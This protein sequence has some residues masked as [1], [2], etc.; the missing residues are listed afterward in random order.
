MRQRVRD[1]LMV[2]FVAGVATAVAS[3][4]LSQKPAAAPAR[5]TMDAGTASGMAAMAAGGGGAMAMLRGQ[6]N[7]PVRELYLR[8]GS[9]QAP[10]GEAKADHFLPDGTRL[11]AS[12]PLLTPRTAS[13]SR[14][15]YREGNMQ[16]PKGRLLLFWGCGEKAGPGQ[17]VVIDFAKMAQGQVPPGLYSAAVDAAEAWQVSAANARTFGEW[18]NERNNKAVPANASLLGAHRVA[19]NYAPEIAFTLA[20]DFMPALQPVSRDAAGGAVALS[21]NA[22]PT[23]TGYYASAIAT[24]KDGGNAND[25][26]WW[27]SSSTQQFGGPMADWLSPAAVRKLVAAKTVMPASQTSCTIPAEV[28]AAGGPMLMTTLYGYGPQADFS[29]PARPAKAAANWQ[30]DWIARVR[31]RANAMVMHGMPGGGMAAYGNDDGEEDQA[32]PPQ[33]KPRCKGLAGMAARAA[34]LC[35]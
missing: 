9:A 5:Y 4:V 24:G 15:P 11:G 30:P 16:M 32:A 13:G 18:P 6:G 26:V 20:D 1:A 22:L 34:G 31:F 28:K 25:M 10:A 12:V 8:L 27:S 21:W 33:T 23:A 14:E 7:Q 17:P 2:S 3:P 35:Q 19:S 29:Y